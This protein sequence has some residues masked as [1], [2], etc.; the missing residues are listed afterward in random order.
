[1]FFFCLSWKKAL[2]HY[3]LQIKSITPQPPSTANS[4]GRCVCYCAT[5]NTTKRPSLL[6]GSYVPSPHNPGQSKSGTGVHLF[7][8]TDPLSGVHIWMRSSTIT[9][10]PPHAP[11]AP[12]WILGIFIRNHTLTRKHCH[13]VV[14]A[15]GLLSILG[16]QK[17]CVHNKNVWSRLLNLSSV[18][19]IISFYIFHISM[20]T[21]EIFLHCPFTQKCHQRDKTTLSRWLKL[22]L[23]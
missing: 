6:A 2:C 13:T 16:Y 18:K 20:L 4:P 17:S 7:H 19:P 3:T 9:I 1:M 5:A 22:M 10:T 21:V 23:M 11:T 15:A 12:E 14:D 8:L